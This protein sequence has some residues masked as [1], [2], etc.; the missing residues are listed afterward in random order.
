MSEGRIGLDSS[1]RISVV[2]P[3]KNGAEFIPALSHT[4]DLNLGKNDEI[5]V[6]EDH[7]DDNSFQELNLWAK[8]NEKVRVIQNRGFGIVEALNFGIS[9]SKNTWI[10]RF[11]VDDLYAN[12]RLES[13]RKFLQPDT[14]AVFS[15]YSFFSNSHD[16]LGSIQSAITNSA[17]KLSLVSG[18]RTAHSSAIFN[19]YAFNHAGGYRKED[20][21]AEDL[22]LWLRLSRLGDF[23]SVPNILMKYRIGLNSVTA[24]RRAESISKKEELLRKIGIEDSVVENAINEWDESLNVYKHFENESRRKLLLFRDIIQSGKM[25][26]KS[27]AGLIKNRGLI[28]NSLKDP[29]I[30]PAVRDL[31]LEKRLRNQIRTQ[32]R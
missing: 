32:I 14:V 17:T 31:F 23:C 1:T 29:R 8:R 7:S 30:L 27:W 11:D 18:Q 22:S 26:E 3:V 5:L 20:F 2:M 21:P 24:T 13:Q 15:D 6:I 12:N 9:E 19:K 25:E 4:L 16:N 28:L 10:A